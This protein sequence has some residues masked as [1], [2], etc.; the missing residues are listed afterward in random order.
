MKTVK[1]LIENLQAFDPNTP[2]IVSRDEE[3]N[4]YRKLWGASSGVVEDFAN[5]HH[6]YHLGLAELTPE[7]EKAGYSDEDVIPNGDSVVVIW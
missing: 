6:F 4:G 2:V 5:N 1:D 3:G 7:L